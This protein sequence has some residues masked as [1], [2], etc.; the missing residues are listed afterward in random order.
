MRVRAGSLIAGIICAGA[1]GVTAQAA[2]GAGWTAPKELS[3]AGQSARSPQL[4]VD[5]S[6]VTTA[7]WRRYDGSNYI[8]QASRF[9]GGSW[10]SP[11]DLSAPGENAYD[12]QVAV[13]SSGV[14]TAVWQRF[15]GSNNIIQASRFSGG[16]W[17]SPV[18][19][20]AVGQSVFGGPEAALTPPV[21]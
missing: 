21:W 11:A 2:L 1:F 9:S 7:V 3:V 8:V 16:S 17:Q 19:L 18:D 4:A 15:G 6:G 12:A 14:V 10:S 20:S 13:D 5:S